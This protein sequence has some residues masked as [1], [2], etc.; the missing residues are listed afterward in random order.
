M[1]FQPAKFVSVAAGTH[2]T[3]WRRRNGIRQR[4]LVHQKRS[5]LRMG[6]SVPAAYVTS[7]CTKVNGF[8]VFIAK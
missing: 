5:T 2:V 4:F 1:D 3:H 7:E 6:T 8:V